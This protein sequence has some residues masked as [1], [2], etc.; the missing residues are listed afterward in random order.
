MWEQ[1]R[2]LAGDAAGFVAVDLPG[3]GNGPGLDSESFTM[4]LGARF[5]QHELE[6]RGIERCILCGLS[7]GGYIAFECWKY[8]PEKIAGM[9][10]ASTRPTPDTEE[11]RRARFANAEKIGRGEFEGFVEAQLEKLLSDATRRDRPEIVDR[12]RKLIYDSPQES[13]IA[14][15]LGM[16]ERNDST[17][18]LPTIKVP[19]A[20]IF[21]DQDTI[22]TAEEGRKMATTIPDARLTVIQEA[23]HLCNMEKPQEFNEAVAE[24]MGRVSGG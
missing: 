17:P 6:A 3:F 14:A 1:Q 18:L 23:G 2:Q 8:F 19:V 7:M 13:A 15:L 5:V 21:G 4:K 10:L 12:A 9:V 24:V 11:G 20:L 22:T 16:A